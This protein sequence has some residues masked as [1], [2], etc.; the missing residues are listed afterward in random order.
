MHV[1]T[2]CNTDFKLEKACLCYF[3]ISWACGAYALARGVTVSLPIMPLQYVR[4][5]LCLKSQS[6][7]CLTVDDAGLHYSIVRQQTS[8]TLLGV[9]K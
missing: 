9:F 6:I 2:R 8:L 1:V 3:N 4:Y 5:I 7:Q